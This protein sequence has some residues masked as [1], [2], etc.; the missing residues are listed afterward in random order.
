[1]KK[2]L[3]A[4]CSTLSGERLHSSLD[5]LYARPMSQDAKKSALRMNVEA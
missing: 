2:F 5:M 1:M 3:V 4:T